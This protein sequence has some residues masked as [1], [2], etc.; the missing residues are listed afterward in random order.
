V[1]LA[2]QLEAQH[3]GEQFGNDRVR[4]ILPGSPRLVQVGTTWR[5]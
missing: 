5:F 4:G 2:V 1:T 3:V